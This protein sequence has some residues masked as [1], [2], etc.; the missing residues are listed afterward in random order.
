MT[1]LVSP[2]AEPRYRY[3]C[4]DCLDLIIKPTTERAV[5]MLRTAG[6]RLV[7]V[8]AEVVEHDPAGRPLDESDLASFTRALQ[9]SDNLAALAARADRW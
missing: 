3:T 6:A 5:S 8:P 4:P 9:D 2:V 1:V 7:L